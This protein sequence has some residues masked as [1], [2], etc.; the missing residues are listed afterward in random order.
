M[1]ISIQVMVVFSV[2][3]LVSLLLNGILI[4]YTRA[5]IIQM[6]FISDNIRAL[7]DST[8]SFNAHLKNVYELDMFYG[9]ET[10]AALLQH[11]S[12]LSESLELYNDFYDLFD[13]ESQD[14]DAIE[15]EAV[16]VLQEDM[17]DAA[18]QTQ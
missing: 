18:T 9:D 4:W 5:S 13:D 1:M 3:L 15:T 7:K 17:V 8:L 11:A 14:E 16:E 10:L 2:I 6:T 12:D